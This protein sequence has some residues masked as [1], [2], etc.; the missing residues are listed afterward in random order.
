[1]TE[2]VYFR[3]LH[4]EFLC[5]SHFVSCKNPPSPMSSPNYR[6]IS[7]YSKFDLLQSGKVGRAKLCISDFALK[8]SAYLEA[9]ICLF[10]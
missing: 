7:D 6:Y 1:M 3:K 2:N 8:S 9:G 10:S 4:L 5:L